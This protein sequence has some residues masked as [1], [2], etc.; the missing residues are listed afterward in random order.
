MLTIFFALCT[1]ENNLRN[2]RL[3]NRDRHHFFYMSINR[4]TRMPALKLATEFCRQTEWLLVSPSFHF[5]EKGEKKARK[6]TPS[7]S[8]MLHRRPRRATLCLALIPVL[9]LFYPIGAAL[10]RRTMRRVTHAPNPRLQIACSAAY[11]CSCPFNV[12]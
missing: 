7:A 4:A 3:C 6:E 2:D 1:A 9:Y 12:C 5:Y 11:S 10:F 8:W